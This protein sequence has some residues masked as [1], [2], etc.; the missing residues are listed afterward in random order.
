MTMIW[1]RQFNQRVR[2]WRAELQR[3]LYTP[4]MPIEF[5]GF[6]TFDRLTPEAAAAAPKAPYRPGTA[7][8]AC[9]EYG[10][11]AAEVTLPESCEGQRI[12]LLSGLEGEQLVFEGG[13]AK[14]SLDKEHHYVTLRRS[15]KAGEKLSLLVESYAGHGARLENITPTP[16]ER[17][18]VPPTPEK[19]C[20]VGESCLAAWNED[21]FQ[22]MIDVEVL[23]SLLTI[24]PE[25]SLRAQK[26]AKALDEF[27]HI[28]D[29]E[30][31]FEARN[32][33]FR[34]A[35]E[36]LQPVLN[37]HNGSTAPKMWL[38]ANSHIDLAWLW[39]VRE[40][41]HKSARTY[42]N[43]LT[44]MEEYPEYSFLLCEPMLL[45]MLKVQNPE[46]WSRVVEA[47]KRGQ[48]KAEGVFYVECD[49]NIPSGESLI[50][51]IMRGKKWFR[52][53]FGVDS[54]V[55]WQPDTFGYSAVLPQ[56]LKGFDVPYFATQKLLRCD[57]ECERF[58]YQNFIWEGMDGSTVKSLS[59]F[60]SNS[61]V[62]PF[63]FH[64]RWE[65]NRTQMQDIDTLLYPYGYGDGGG[66]PTRDQLETVRRLKDLE[67]APRSDYGDLTEFFDT[68]PEPD[69]RWVGELYLAWHRGTYTVQR[70][71]KTLIRRLER[72]IHDAEMLLPGEEGR[73]VLQKTWD[74]LMLCQFH[75]VAGGVGIARVH[76]EATSWMTARIAELKALTAQLLGKRITAA[77]GAY[78]AFNPL[79]WARKGWIQLP[80]GKEVWAELPA[81]GM[82]TLDGC[83]AAPADVSASMEKSL[84][85]LRNAHLSAVIDEKGRVI[86][87]ADETGLALMNPGQAMNDWRLYQNVE[88]VYDGWELSRDWPSRD[89]EE[90]FD[91]TV[92][93]T[94][95]TAEKAE[96]T[97]TRRFSKSTSV[98][99]IRLRAGSRQLDF[100][101]KVSWHERHRM[102][103]VHFEHNVLCEEAMHEMQFGHVRRPA[104]RSGA[105]ASDRY[106]VIQHH[107]TALKEENR[108]FAVLNDGVWGLSCNRGDLSLTILRAPLVP[109]DTAD[110]GD[111][112]FTY[113]IMPFTGAF[114]DSGVVQAGYE[115]NAPVTVLPGC[116][117]ASTGAWAEGSLIVETVKAAEDGNGVIIRLYESQKTTCTAQVHLPFAGKVYDCGM[118]E[119]A[120]GELLGEGDVV[121][122][123]AKPF[124]VVTLRLV[125]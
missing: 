64:T 72:A 48:I 45:D 78:T 7:W 13:I 27:T 90:E 63:D 57:P 123:T 89:L 120:P 68:M 88:P 73:E 94:A 51:Q 108:G 77:E 116:C 59:Y 32:E 97:V 50:R 62:S 11:F 20:K 82:A 69:N 81:S 42:S 14:G 83:A 125:P 102:L 98:Q 8:G 25:K 70:R 34:R 54:K 16:P 38:V 47:Q 37:C 30:L 12:V 99:I 114:A 31:P 85:T 86:S 18:G 41:F 93:L 103:K 33:T 95:C 19:Q 44:L 36:A 61:K 58:P 115:L 75:D 22:L 53:T 121:E 26:V 66:G 101:T 119:A 112:S 124:Q 49:T 24:L 15:A 71:T 1:G 55:A 52:D 109:D 39:P 91:T 100:E 80:S 104:H 87:L 117:E 2:A 21:A 79:P 40:T 10:W 6:T 46:V 60:N 5:S 23:A 17:P 35:R 3:H 56:L 65:T 118:A 76:A 67:G 113:A 28:C 96:L 84:F 107:W 4:V 110:R 106:E 29:F 74:T 9:W 122:I 92:E 43:Q 111:H 105:F